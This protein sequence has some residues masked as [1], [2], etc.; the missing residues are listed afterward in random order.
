MILSL[1]ARRH[2]VALIIHVA[3]EGL[4]SRVALLGEWLPFTE[5]SGV[6]TTLVGRDA[7]REIGPRRG[8]QRNEQDGEADDP[9]HCGI[10]HLGALGVN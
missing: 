2:A 1:T 6:V 3:E 5:R 4:G 9:L 8:G 10:A 7:V